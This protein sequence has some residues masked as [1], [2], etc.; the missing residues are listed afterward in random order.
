MSIVIFFIQ[1]LAVYEDDSDVNNEATTY[2]SDSDSSICD[3]VDESNIKIPGNGKNK[4]KNLVEEIK[5]L[6]D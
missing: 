3:A 1:D 6:E 2:T 4:C 5:D